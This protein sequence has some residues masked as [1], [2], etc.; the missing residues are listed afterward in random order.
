MYQPD[1]MVGELQRDIQLLAQGEVDGV[2]VEYFDPHTWKSATILCTLPR[3]Q[4]L[5]LS[6][7]RVVGI[8]DKTKAWGYDMRPRRIQGYR[9][10][11]FTFKTE[12]DGRPQQPLFEL[13]RPRR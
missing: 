9:C 4:G 12:M 11:R 3:D 1:N 5:S 13:V 8:T 6:K 7:V 10:T 2:E